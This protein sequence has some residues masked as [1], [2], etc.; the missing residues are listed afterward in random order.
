MQRIHQ[1]SKRQKTYGIQKIKVKKNYRIFF[2]FDRNYVSQITNREKNKMLKEKRMFLIGG[3][4]QRK[5]G[6]F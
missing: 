1:S 3:E 5:G 2:F 4:G 6:E